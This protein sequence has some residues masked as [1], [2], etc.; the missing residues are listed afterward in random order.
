MIKIDIEYICDECGFS[1]K[2]KTIIHKGYEDCYYILE[3]KDSGFMP[4]GWS[5]KVEKM[6][7]TKLHC[8]KCTK[9]NIPKDAV[10]VAC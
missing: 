4:S 9:K 5:Y 10:I 6:D 3:N 2:E 8:K 7:K 1:K